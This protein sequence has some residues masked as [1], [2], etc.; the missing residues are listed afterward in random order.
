MSQHSNPPPIIKFL[1]PI[2]ACVGAII[3]CERPQCGTLPTVYSSKEILS[4]GNGSE[5][6]SS[7]TFYVLQNFTAPKLQS[8]N[9]FLYI[10]FQL[11]CWLSSMVL[12]IGGV[13]SL[14]EVLLMAPESNMVVRSFWKVVQYLKRFLLFG[15]LCAAMVVLLFAQCLIGYCFFIFSMAL[16]FGNIN[17]GHIFLLWLLLI[18]VDIS[19]WIVAGLRCVTLLTLNFVGVQFFGAMFGFWIFVLVL[20]RRILSNSVVFCVW[21]G[22]VIVGVPHCMFT[23]VVE[24][25]FSPKVLFL[26]VVRVCIDLAV[27][28]IVWLVITNSALARSVWQLPVSRF[29]VQEGYRCVFGGVTRRSFKSSSISAVGFGCGKNGSCSVEFYLKGGTKRG[30]SANENAEDRPVHIEKSNLSAAEHMVGKRLKKASRKNYKGKLN[31]LKVF[32]ME[33]ESRQQFLGDDNS[34]RIPLPAG[35]VKELFGWISKNTDLPKKRQKVGKERAR[36][37]EENE[38]DEDET[39]PFMSGDDFFAESKV[40]VSVSCMQGYKSA[41]KAF[42]EDSLVNFDAELDAWLDSF[43]QGYKKTIAEKKASGVMEIKEGKS[44]IAFSGHCFLSKVLMTLK[45]EKRKYYFTESI[46]GWCFQ[47]LAWNLIARS[48]SIQGIMLQHMSWR[49]DCLVINFPLHKGD[50]TG[51][52]LAKDKHVYA[53]PLKPEIC[54]MLAVAVLIFCRHRGVGEGVVTQ[55]FTGD[56]VDKFGAMLRVDFA[57]K[58]LIPEDI[59]MGSARQDLGTHSNWK[60]AATYLCGSIGS[61]FKCCCNLSSC[62]VVSWQSS[63]SIYFF[64]SRQ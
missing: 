45:P 63:R 41:L 9:Q 21:T 32:F 1:V 40:T 57:D 48:S 20:V 60:G 13:L 52:S 51:E 4:S 5:Q 26:R 28:I 2:L 62:W 17:A 25:L 53:N 19:V 43:I 46:F 33:E 7:F 11:S 15:F 14:V 3:C 22:C 61:L 23:W 55:L 12:V 10:L 56:S 6:W 37:E 24:L 64:Q 47:V 39:T 58:N 59:D 29:W 18:L 36:P 42:Y 50:Q 16:V 31:T 34:I 38:G 8:L 27:C 44:P 35:I 30:F 54:P 49:G